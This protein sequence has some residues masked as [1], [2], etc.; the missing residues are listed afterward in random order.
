MYIGVV[1]GAVLI[2]PVDR[3]VSPY[4]YKYCE[5]GNPHY[6]GRFRVLV[7]V[8]E[9]ARLHVIACKVYGLGPETVLQGTRFRR[10]LLLFI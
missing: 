5:G 1:T 7:P 2:V 9:L 8:V 6:L 3:T 4:E 10:C